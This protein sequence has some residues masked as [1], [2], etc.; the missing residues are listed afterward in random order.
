MKDLED[1]LEKIK[2]ELGIEEKVKI[3]LKDYK[4]LIAS[5]SLKKNIIRINRK[6]IDKDFVEKKLGYRTYEDF[7]IKILKHELMHIKL[8][9]KWHIP[10]YFEKLM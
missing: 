1:L 5:T 4:K 9:T 7:I 10:Q 8:K 3:E 6:I 2:K